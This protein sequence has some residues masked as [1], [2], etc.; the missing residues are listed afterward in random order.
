MVGSQRR[1]KQEKENTKMNILKNRAVSKAALVALVFA[2]V[3]P[4]AKVYAGPFATSYTNASLIG[5]YGFSAQGWFLG[6]GPTAVLSASV[7]IVGVMSFDGNGTFS[8]HDTVDLGGTL[9]HHGTAANPIVGTYTV[10]PDG[11][12]TMQWA[13]HTRLFAIVAGGTELQFGSA[14]PQDTDRGVA[15]KQ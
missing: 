11:T 12:G 15:K 2:V 8:F 14:D 10:N 5:V 13:D 9:V 3:L 4:L 1:P 6:P 7:D